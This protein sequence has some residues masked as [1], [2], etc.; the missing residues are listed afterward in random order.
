[1]GRKLLYHQCFSQPDNVK[2][3]DTG[4]KALASLAAGGE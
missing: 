3:A 4:G 1:M 2:C